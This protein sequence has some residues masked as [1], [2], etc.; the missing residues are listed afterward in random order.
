MKELAFLILGTLV[1]IA[2]A[3]VWILSNNSAITGVKDRC[4]KYGFLVIDSRVYQCKHI[5]GHQV[6]V[7]FE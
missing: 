3:M 6:T 7:E 2:M 4:D 5:P 1:L